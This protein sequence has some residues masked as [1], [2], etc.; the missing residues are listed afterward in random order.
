MLDSIHNIL[1]FSPNSFYS[2]PIFLDSHFSPF[3]SFTVQVIFCNIFRNKAGGLMAENDDNMDM[4]KNAKAERAWEKLETAIARM[5]QAAKAR[6]P[7]GASETDSGEIDELRKKN[8]TLK[9][10]HQA[11]SARL[12]GAIGQLKTILES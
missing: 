2:T 1:V 5:E 11:V 10:A 7:A 9:E 6:P 8:A 12:D 3:D 4:L